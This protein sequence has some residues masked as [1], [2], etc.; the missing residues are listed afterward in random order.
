MSWNDDNKDEQRRRNPI[1]RRREVIDELLV[2][3]YEA[4][5]GYGDAPA[6][7]KLQ[8]AAHLRAYRRLLANHSDH[9]ALRQ[10]WDDFNVDWIKTAA[11][12][13]V[14]VENTSSGWGG[15]VES[16]NSTQPLLAEVTAG[17]FEDL[18]ESLDAIANDLGFIEEPD[19]AEHVDTVT[20]EDLRELEIARGQREPDPDEK[21]VFNDDG[22]K[23]G[24]A[25]DM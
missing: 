17:Q 19:E 25:G 8:L 7:L 21:P 6:D 18:A 5:Q 14:T 16:E 23:I 24:V 15:S 20:R 4:E 11:S 13:R 9:G 2:A 10:E 12:E 1:Y 3:V 22:E